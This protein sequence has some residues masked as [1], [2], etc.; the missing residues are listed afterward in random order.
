MFC[1]DSKDRRQR[2]LINCDYY[3]H[4]VG[5]PLRK[6]LEFWRARSCSLLA[7]LLVGRHQPVFFGFWS[8]MPTNGCY[9]SPIP[10]SMARKQTLKQINPLREQTHPSKQKSFVVQCVPCGGGSLKTKT[11]IN[12]ETRKDIAGRQLSLSD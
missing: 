4:Y 6:H 5:F 10:N 3:G 2:R 7:F 1:I 8:Y 12:T 11:K 9:Q